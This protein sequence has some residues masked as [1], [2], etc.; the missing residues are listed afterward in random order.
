MSLRFTI[1]GAG[2][3][4]CAVGAALQEAGNSVTFVERRGSQVAA[5]RATGLTVRCGNDTASLAVDVRLPDEVTGDLGIVLVCVGASE[6]QSV[7]EWCAT[8]LSDGEFVASLQNG[9]CADVVAA[10]L[11][12]DRAVAAFVNFSAD[13]TGDGDVHWVPPESFAIALGELDGQVTPRVRELARALGALAPVIT[14][15]NVWG[16]LWGKLGYVNV[17]VATG[18]TDAT[19]ADAIEDHTDLMVELACEVYDVADAE[20]IRLEGFD[21]VQPYILYPRQHR[22]DALVKRV[23]SDLVAHRRRNAMKR[24][25]LWR[26]LVGHRRTSVE[27]EL[28]AVVAMGARHQL[29]LPLTRRLIGMVLEVEAGDRSLAVRNLQELDQDRRALLRQRDGAGK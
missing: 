7:S 8:R 21:N 4:G 25:G 3:I 28:G 9:L 24:S 19:M 14:T 16:Y 23:M 17:L 26:A 27:A 11:G 6:T 2:A 12:R 22:R 18:I 10:T 5:L 15:S 13:S 29:T 1:V 20:G